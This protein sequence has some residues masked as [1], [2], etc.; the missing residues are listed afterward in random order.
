MSNR[1]K[2]KNL[3]LKQNRCS[4]LSVSR[5]LEVV[6]P[7]LYSTLWCLGTRLTPKWLHSR[8]LLISDDWGKP[9]VTF[10]RQPM[11]GKKG[12]SC[13]LLFWRFPG[14]CTDHFHLHSTS[15]NLITR[16]FQVIHNRLEN[17]GF[18]PGSPRAS[19]VTKCPGLPRTKGFHNT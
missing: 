5:S 4:L 6:S 10:M 12:R 11:E 7:E 15:Q 8:F 2:K 13:S 3:R 9:E 17:V 14:G 19:W 18:S 16:S 1:K